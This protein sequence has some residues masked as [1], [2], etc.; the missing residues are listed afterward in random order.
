MVHGSDRTWSE[1]L[2]TS[3]FLL[4]FAL[5]SPAQAQDASMVLAF[6]AEPGAPLPHAYSYGAAPTTDETFTMRVPIF[7][8]EVAPVFADSELTIETATKIVKRVH[9]ERAFKSLTDCSAAKAIVEKKLA[10]SMPTPYTG[11]NPAWQYA[12]GQAVGGIEC[13]MGRHLPYPILT[14]DLAAAPAP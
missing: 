13:V 10:A 4:A 2:K 11:T 1:D 8:R 7:E 3:L 5:A 6:G 9:I 14:L 12:K